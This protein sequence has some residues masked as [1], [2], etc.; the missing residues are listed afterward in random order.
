MM[1]KM[2]GEL[3]QWWT[4]L[5]DPSEYVEEAAFFTKIFVTA[6]GCLN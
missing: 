1:E 6:Q 2:Y 4:L 5:S 3:A